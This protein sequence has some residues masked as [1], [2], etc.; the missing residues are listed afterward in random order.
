MDIQMS[1]VFLCISNKHLTAEIKH[2]QLSAIIEKKRKLLRCK[3][4]YIKYLQGL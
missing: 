4:L 3:N 2:V 1:V